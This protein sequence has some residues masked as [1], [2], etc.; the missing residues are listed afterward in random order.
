[1]PLCGIKRRLVLLSLLLGIAACSTDFSRLEP[2]DRPG[3][4]FSPEGD[5]KATI[6]AVHGFNDYSRAFEDFGVYAASRGYLV[7]AFDQQGFGR[8]ANS[9]SW[10][11]YELLIED[12]NL[13]IAEH[14]RKR[15]AQPIYVLGE[16]MG[17]AVAMLALSDVKTAG[18][19]GLI[20]SAPAVWGGDALN[21]FYRTALWLAAGVAPGWTFTGRGLGVQASDNVPMLRQ[22]GADPLFIKET[23]LEAIQG[24]VELMG[25]ARLAGPT[26]QLPRLVLDGRNDEVVPPDAISSFTARLSARACRRITYD[27]GWHLLL[28]DLQRQRVWDDILIWLDDPIRSQIGR[29]CGAE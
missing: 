15:P 27:E 22:L 21:P 11:G 16:S 29:P 14:R 1:M 24:L 23:R 3:L 13:R 8:N 10:P 2:G 4:E 20:M 28:R 26:L 17:A 9:G 6:I 19:D 7:D 18:A 25:A 12:L 5:V